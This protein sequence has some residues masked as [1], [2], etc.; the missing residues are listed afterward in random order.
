MGQKR[1]LIT[2][3]IPECEVLKV[4]H[5]GSRNS[6]CKEFNERVNPEIAIISLGEDN[7]YGF[8]HKETIDLLGET[9]ILRTDECADITVSAELSGEY[10]LK[11]H[12]IAVN[13]E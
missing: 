7:T 2:K 9:E 1:M 11:M 10:K 4:P 6:A 12:R 8:P 13:K 3:N 5:H